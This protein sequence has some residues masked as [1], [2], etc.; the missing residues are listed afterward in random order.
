MTRDQLVWVIGHTKTENR[1]NN[2]YVVSER[3]SLWSR[4]RH[5]KLDKTLIF[6][7][8]TFVKKTYISAVT[9]D[10]NFTEINDQY[11]N[12]SSLFNIWKGP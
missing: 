9:F 11:T 12:F 2:T 5:I 8:F 6:F 3:Q 1:H 10:I 4:W 7:N